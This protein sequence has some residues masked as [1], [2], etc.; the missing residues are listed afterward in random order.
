MHIYSDWEDIYSKGDII[1]RVSTILR[2]ALT[3]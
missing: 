3:R 1:E 2:K